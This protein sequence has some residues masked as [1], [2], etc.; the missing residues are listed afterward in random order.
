MKKV[1]VITG[2]TGVGKTNL[3]I[4][5][6]KKFKAEIINADASQVHRDLNIGTAKIKA[7]EMQGVKH[8]LLDFLKVEE[9][10]SIK[11]Y[12]DLGR[13]LINEIELPFI[14]GGSG[15]YIQALVTDYNLE[16]KPRQED[17]YDA[18]TNEELYDMLLTL[19]QE[20]ALKLHP[21]NRRRVIR[22]IELAKENGKVL[23]VEPTY[24]FDTLTICLTR[25]RDSLYE[26]INERCDEMI[27]NGW[28]EE[29]EKLRNAGVNLKRVKEIGYTDLN[30]YLDGLFTLDE[31]KEII[32]QKTRRYAKRQMTWFRNKMNCQFV[33]LD[34]DSFDM[35][36]NLI[37]EFLKQ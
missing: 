4:A 37:E 7:S 14:V 24:L 35:I 8:H 13:Q 34:N 31:T 30:N 26:R 33:D 32:K 15:L 2:P 5:L 27:N 18:Y 9:D 3:S 20:A 6:A 25:N 1:I 28:I 22:Y 23:S 29:C 11:D 21:N 10:F 17:A 12:Q 16:S 19:D 36:H